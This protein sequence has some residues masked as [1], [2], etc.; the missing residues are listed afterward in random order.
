[1]KRTLL[2]LTLLLLTTTLYSQSITI[3]DDGIDTDNDGVPDLLDNCPN[4][5]NPDQLD[6]RNNGLGDVCDPYT[7]IISF[8]ENT[9][10][11]FGFSVNFLFDE[12]LEIITFWED[13][14]AFRLK[15][16][17]IFVE[18]K[19]N[20]LEKDFYTAKV[21]T[22]NSPDSIDVLIFV[23]IVF[24]DYESRAGIYSVDQVSVGNYSI[25]NISPPNSFD[26]LHNSYYERVGTIPGELQGMA[27]DR[28]FI[29]EDIN[30]DGKNDL[31]VG[32]QSVTHKGRNLNIHQMSVPV[33]L[34]NNGE[35][36]TVKRNSFFNNTIF[37]TP[38]TLFQADIDNDGRSEVINLGEHYHAAI[39]DHHAHYLYTRSFL[40]SK[41]LRLGID[42]DENDHKLHRYYKWYENNELEDQVDKYRY[43][44]L[45][46]SGFLS[47][48]S[49]A[50]GDINNDGYIDY[51]V[52]SRVSS[53]PKYGNVLDVLVNDRNGGFIIH[54]KGMTEYYGSEGEGLLIDINGDGFKDLI[55][56][57][58]EYR[59]NYSE[60][61][62]AVFFNDQ[63]NFFDLNYQ[64]FDQMHGS[65]GLRNIYE[66][67]LNSDGK[68]EVIAY[69]STGYGCNGCGLTMEDIPNLIKIY[70]VN[71]GV[72]TEVSDQYFFGNQNLMNFYTQTGHL[73]YI[74]LDGDGYKDLVPRFSLE[75]P[76]DGWWGYPENAYRG[77]WNDSK[78]FQ[79]FRFNPITMKFDLID[80]GPT[81][82]F[83]MGQHY[84]G[85]LY[86]SFDFVDFN[87]DGY[88]EWLSLLKG[89][90]DT[91]LL[92][93]NPIYIQ[94]L[95]LD[96]ELKTEK[97]G[98]SFKLSW[99]MDSKAKN[100]R[101]EL[102]E[103]DNVI[104]DTLLTNNEFLVENFGAN[105]SNIE[106]KV[107]A[108]NLVH[109]GEWSVNTFSDTSIE[110]D[111]IPS[112]YTLV[113]NYPNP[114]NP[115]TQIRFA[116]PESQQVTIRV[117]DVN[118]R[119]VSELVNNQT[120]SAGNHQVSFDGT[121]LSTGI[122]IY[123]LTT[124]S[125]FT[126]SRKLVLIK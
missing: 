46:D 7:K 5:W 13:S 10:L 52:T 110:N 18:K 8:L 48:Y 119:M 111:L 90:H 25:I 28:F 61:S 70:E 47:H 12:D 63:N 56:G 104:L 49:S 23:D 53:N 15:N 85:S 97:Q 121:G 76:S 103:S 92:I 33:Y 91:N 9:P 108:L 66:A 106:A 65:L 58:G 45:T 124:N 60:S 27:F 39:P 57:G 93:I 96:L 50:L 109:E 69:F 3:G 75:D 88:L 105:Y 112:E 81:R 16:D 64:V 4:I 62:I 1:M 43:N 51:V 41:G 29:V 73:K 30:N 24:D 82:A 11:G 21:M 32:D 34:I 101:L 102:K 89:N 55:I 35:S 115:T 54:R 19:L 80:L 68:S 59:N 99:N 22:K 44:D 31:V 123:N 118:G 126:M 72:L 95:Y 71:N 113:Q 114:F 20:Y 77:D 79:F 122:Y 74:D 40:R 78:G 98:D 37:H 6:F 42:Y 83:N 84:D 116:L 125:G 117:Y 38:Q 2:T 100:Y 17:S 107:R 26:Y 36:F 86:N 87:N 94:P 14:N 67:D 120:Y